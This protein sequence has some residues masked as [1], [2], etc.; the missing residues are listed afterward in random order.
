MV[1]DSV[2]VTVRSI[3]ISGPFLAVGQYVAVVVTDIPSGFTPLVVVDKEQTDAK[4]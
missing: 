1:I 4:N 3:E 2:E